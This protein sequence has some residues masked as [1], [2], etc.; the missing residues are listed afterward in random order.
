[1]FCGVVVIEFRRLS[2][3]TAIT[4]YGHGSQWSVW[5]V[6]SERSHIPPLNVS[7]ALVLVQEK[8]AIDCLPQRLW[9]FSPSLSRFARRTW[10]KCDI[11]YVNSL[12][13]DS[14]CPLYITIVMQLRS[15]YR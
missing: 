14:F 5:S 1:M 15:N 11:N 8:Q 9:R 6:G 2:R 12:E 10:R 7:I 3:I 4:Q 13:K